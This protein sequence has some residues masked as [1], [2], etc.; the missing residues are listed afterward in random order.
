MVLKVPCSSS[1]TLRSSCRRGNKTRHPQLAL[2][3]PRQ[4]QGGHLARLR[5]LC[6]FASIE[7][8]PDGFIDARPCAAWEAATLARR[9]LRACRRMRCLICSQDYIDLVQKL[10]ISFADLIISTIIFDLWH[11]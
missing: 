10:F 2:C 5:A 9:H 11:S 3:A 7:Q 1:V 6:A 4:G 8:P